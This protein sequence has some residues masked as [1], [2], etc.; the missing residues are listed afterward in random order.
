[1]TREVMV[2]RGAARKAVDKAGPGEE[3]QQQEQERAGRQ[4]L[5]KQNGTCVSLSA[6]KV[7]DS[8]KSQIPTGLLHGGSS[9]G[10]AW[11]WGGKIR[12]L[13]LNELNWVSLP[14]GHSNGLCQE[15]TS[16]CEQQERHG[17]EA[18]LWELARQ[19]WVKWE[20][21]EEATKSWVGRWLEAWEPEENLTFFYWEEL[22]K[23]KTKTGQG[24]SLKNK[25]KC[26]REAEWNVWHI[27]SPMYVLEMSR[28][29]RTK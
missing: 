25:V 5:G 3:Q 1:M 7:N 14:L 4:T 20:D 16:C 15:S 27:F 26:H 22:G 21:K 17:V 18:F 6:R 24:G 23:T 2:G 13:V 12:K 8:G 10:A 9:R 29:N 28:S 19:K 11:A